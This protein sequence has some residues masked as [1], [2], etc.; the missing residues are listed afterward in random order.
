MLKDVV[1]MLIVAGER[2]HLDG[3][4][5]V[6]SQFH[7]ASQL[8]GRL[9]FLNAQ[10]LAR[11]N[12]LHRAFAGHSLAEGSQAIAEGRVL[13]AVTGEVFRWQP[14]TMV[15][16]ISDQLMQELERRTKAAEGAESAARF[17]LRMVDRA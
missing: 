5:F 7:V 14:E 1:A 4:V 12:A 16:P 11:Y 8:H 2:L 15:L 3:L 10:A 17:E 13:D 9:F 6:P